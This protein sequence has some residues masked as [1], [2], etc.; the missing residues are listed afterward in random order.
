M[1]IFG[2]FL[3]PKACIFRAARPGLIEEGDLLCTRFGVTGYRSIGVTHSIDIVAPP[4]SLPSLLHSTPI[5]FIRLI[6]SYCSLARNSRTTWAVSS[7][8]F[9]SNSIS[10]GVSIRG[11]GEGPISRWSL[12]T[13]GGILVFS[14]LLP[15]G[16]SVS[17]TLAIFF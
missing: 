13:E 6:E 3:T 12:T 5:S 4:A 8:H 10:Y 1:D 7:A 15:E 11:A 16:C 9:R 14:S 2:L 17:L